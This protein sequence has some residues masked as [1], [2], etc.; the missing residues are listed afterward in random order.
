MTN[1]KQARVS[2]IVKALCWVAGVR[3]DVIERVPESLGQPVT[4]GLLLLL[5][6]SLSGITMGFAVLR[7]FGGG[8]FGWPAAIGGGLLWTGIIFCIERS[9]L[10]GMDKTK[11]KKH[12]WFQVA[13][14]APLALAIGITVSQPLL[15]RISQTVL[16]KQLYDMKEKDLDSKMERN[17][18]NAHLPETT[19]EAEVLKQAQV[20]QRQRA[21]GEPDSQEYLDAK[22]TESL[23]QK[24][25]DGALRTYNPRI[26]RLQ[27]E[28]EEIGR[29]RRGDDS[30]PDHSEELRQLVARYQREIFH[31]SAE[32]GTARR[33]VDTATR[34]WKESEE[35]QLKDI[36]K[37]LTQAR[38]D[39]DAAR[40]T[41]NKNNQVDET[42]MNSLM[43]FNLVNEYTTLKQI[44]NDPT[45]PK[46]KTMA[47]F[48]W[49]LALLFFTLELTPVSIKAF[50]RRT[51]VDDATIAAETADEERALNATNLAI[52]GIQK[53]T[54]VAREVEDLALEM[55]RDGWFERLRRQGEVTSQDLQKIRAE[56][57]PLALPV[58]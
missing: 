15:L 32:L 2:P 23:A 44:E 16:D 38:D 13:I 41:T 17:S 56:S 9:L 36:G 35:Q 43:A 40:T 20:A 37:R 3:A 57:K 30:Q 42:N 27:T 49:E 26:T 39:R 22:K 47:H 51:P 52:A 10:L 14:R 48:E 5:T 58:A 29:S 31:A 55:W 50:G 11:D 54:E 34:A 18:H 28:M 6:P 7:I 1:N 12:Q 46:S 53:A 33:N 8:V 25:Y 45:N 4:L 19:R 21:Q 24:N